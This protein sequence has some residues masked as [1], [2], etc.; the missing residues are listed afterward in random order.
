MSCGLYAILAVVLLAAPDVVYW[1]FT[2]AGGSAGDFIAKRAAALFAG[3]ATLAFLARRLSESE[4]RIAVSLGMVVALA[5]LAI[6]GCYEFA[7]GFAGAGIWL[8]ISAEL[9]F[10]AAFASFALS[11]RRRLAA[12]SA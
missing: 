11:D 12:S 3:L 8:A 5:G 10:A 6:I 2:V 9:G 7:R 4:G 1:I